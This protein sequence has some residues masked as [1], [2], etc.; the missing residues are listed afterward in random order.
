MARRARKTN[1]VPTIE[2]IT[3][4]ASLALVIAA[5]G[6]IA[7]E[8]IRDEGALPDLHVEVETIRPSGSGY[9]VTVTVRNDARQAAADVVVQAVWQ[10][11]G[12]RAMTGDLQ[13]D[14]VP[15]LSERQVTFVFPERP[16]PTGLELR[17]VAFTTP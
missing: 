4:L 14:Y 9:A 8:A 7:F 5:M 1:S 6:F 17:V 12:A 3:G 13:L 10:G 16:D 11:A 15:G 2:W